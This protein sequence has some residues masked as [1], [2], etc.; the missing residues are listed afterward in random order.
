M[1]LDLIIAARVGLVEPSG[2]VLV[3]RVETLTDEFDKRTGKWGTS[4]AY[5]VPAIERV[6][7]GSTNDLIADAIADMNGLARDNRAD[8]I[9]IVADISACG[10]PFMRSFRSH[11]IQAAPVMVGDAGVARV[12]GRHWSIPMRELLS[13]TLGLLAAQKIEVADVEH[14]ATLSNQ[15]DAFRTK[16]MPRDAL[17]DWRLVP[18]VDLAGALMT[19]VWWGERMLRTLVKQPPPKREPIVIRQPTFNEAM[20]ANE[21]RRREG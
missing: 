12:S 20:E 4:V 21:R 3:S 18:D 8:R 13:V 15:L 9:S 19:A 11:K 6:P 1:P 10:A 2:V 16:P 17:S 14:A 5:Q 7:G